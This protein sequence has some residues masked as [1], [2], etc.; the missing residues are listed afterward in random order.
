MEVV[1]SIRLGWDVIPNR[2]E[3]I[4]E[5]NM[6]GELYKGKERINVEIKRRTNRIRINAKSIKI[7]SAFVLQADKRYRAALKWLFEREEVDLILKERVEGRATIE[8]E[9]EGLHTESMVGFYRSH[10]MHNGKEYSFLTTQFEPTG[11]RMAFPCFDEPA[12]KAVFDISLVVDNGVETISNMEKLSVAKTGKKTIVRF[13]E[14]PRMSTYLVYMGVGTFERL[15]GNAGGTAISV[16]TTPGK[17]KLGT[18]ALSY[19]KEVVQFYE[20]YFGIKYQLPKLD[21]IAVPDFAV[22]AMENWGA[23]TFREVRLLCDSRTAATDAK[24][25]ILEYIAHEIAHQWFGD[26]VTMS[27]WDDLWL[28]ESFATY[29][30]YKAVAELYPEWKPMMKYLANEVVRGYNVDSYRTSHPVSVPVADAAR[31]AGMFDDISYRKGGALLRMFCDYVGEEAFKGGL[32]IYLK[33]H[34][35]SNAKREDLWNAIDE[36]LHKNGMPT[37]LSK[38]AEYWIS[39]EGHPLVMVSEKNGM[40]ELSQ[41]RF[42]LSGNKAAKPWPIPMR[43]M[44]MAGKTGLIMLDTAKKTVRLKGKGWIKLNSGQTGFYR[45]KY[46]NRLLDGIGK[47]LETGKLSSADAWNIANDLYAMVRSGEIKAKAYLNFITAHCLDVGYPANYTISEQLGRL[48]AI[49]SGTGLQKKI[50]KALITYN[51]SLLDRVGWGPTKKE[52]STDALAR[53]TAMTWLGRAG[54]P[55]VV[56]RARRLFSSNDIAPDLKE[57]V[58]AAVAANGGEEE[59]RLMKK[60][61]MEARLPEERNVLLMSMGLFEKRELASKALDFTLSKDVR[62]QDSYF[63]PLLMSTTSNCADVLL[64]WQIKNWKKLMQMYDPNTEMLSKEVAYMYWQSSRE[65]LGKIRKLFSDKKNRRGDIEMQI[66]QAQ[67][68]VQ[69]TIRFREINA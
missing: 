5:P 55:K 16:I 68:S 2:Y 8:L 17:V 13:N 47:A 49:S 54:Y 60:R 11:A 57:A 50:R 23:I 65:S 7:K 3:L 37:R 25:T 10:Y 56:E 1:K 41:S 6:H 34:S 27:W 39:T 66:V 12:F 18:L 63:I 19:A 30:S 52:S 35:Y 58:Y 9:F 33:R 67:E 36:Y 38:I 53:S 32:H 43:Y 64:D 20:K 24:Q 31:A 42:T 15:R 61:Y 62:L 45:V 28:N 22:G 59:F 26:L 48:Y 46:Q 44:T 69:S 51:T 4:I 29:M 21:L 14:T 40:L